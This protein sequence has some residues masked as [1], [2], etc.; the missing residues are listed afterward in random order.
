MGIDEDMGCRKAHKMEESSVS[1]QDLTRTVEMGAE[2]K[3]LIQ[4]VCIRLGV[5]L[6]ELIL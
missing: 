3:G 4:A 2:R 6:G 5:E 1:Y